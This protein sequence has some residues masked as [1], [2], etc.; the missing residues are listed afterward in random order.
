MS[1]LPATPPVL[2]G[3]DAV[4]IALTRDAID[5]SVGVTAGPLDRPIG[6]TRLNWFLYRVSTA[7]ALMNM[8]SPQT[9]WTTRRGRPPLALTLHYLLS[10]DP[11]E[12]TTTGNEIEPAHSALTAVMMVLHERPVIGPDT[13]ITAAPPQT[14]S[15]VTDALDGLVEPLRI[16]MD[17]VPLETIT[18]LWGSGTKSLRV[19]IA[20]Q[21]SLVTIASPIAFAPGPPVQ[22]VVNTVGES[23]GPQLTRVQ[24]ALASFGRAVTISAT[25]TLDEFTITLSRSPGDPDDPTDG[26]PNPGTTHSTGP[27]RLIPAPVDGGWEITLPDQT[28]KPG[29]RMLT[30]TNQVDGRAAGSSGARLTV[31]PAVLGASGALQPGS[32]ITLDV[33]HVLQE[34]R[35]AFAGM[36][37]PYTPASPTSITVN[38]PAGVADYAGTEIPV[39]VESGTIAGPPTPLV[40]S[41]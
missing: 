38:V 24:P 29:R 34:G 3:V 18:G 31:A 33:A 26:R 14:A 35:V 40:V 15:Q 10:A 2:A 11:G 25:G 32:P 8:E 21:V 22:Q 4:L 23:A 30:L 7:P 36:M 16:T 19:S 39:S 6:T 13:I 9:G 20:Y 1:V 27:W 37:A 41:P 12:L 17:P 28:M 5:P